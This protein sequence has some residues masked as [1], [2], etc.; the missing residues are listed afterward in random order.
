MNELVS[1]IVP[2]YNCAEYLE[3]CIMSIASQTYENIEILIVNDGSTDNSQQIIERLAQKDARIHNLFQ[4]NQ[5]V[6][7]ARNCA[8]SCAKGDYYIFVDGDDYIGKDYIKELVACAVKNRSELV[9]CGYTLVYADKKKTV[10]VIPQGYKKNE[11]EEWAYRISA[12]C[13]RLYSSGFWKKNDMK[14]VA[15]ENAR[16]ED[17]PLDLFSNAMAENVCIIDKAEY[18]YVQHE[19]SAMNNK[20][21]VTFLFPYNAFQEMYNKLRC[22][23]MTNSRAFFDIGVLKFLA[24]FKYVIYFR[25]DGCE[26]KK[27]N[28]YVHSLLDSDFNRMKLEWKDRKRSIDLPLTHKIAIL[29]FLIQMGNSA[30]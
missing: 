23:E 9:I 21:K 6:A 2:V 7:A 5:G 16:A 8:L 20:Q 1:V 13:S 11:K 19:K 24:M 30:I 14:F 12:V 25:A 22:V 15:E 18:F 17:V 29:L 27:F 10:K 28:K 4:K 3:K 26:K